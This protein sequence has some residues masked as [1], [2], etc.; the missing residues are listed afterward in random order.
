MNSP[1]DSL[2]DSSTTHVWLSPHDPLP[3]TC[4]RCGMFTDHRVK[5]K[6]VNL[7]Q[8]SADESTGCGMLVLHIFLH[9]A[10]GPIGWIISLLMDGGKTENGLKTV[11]EKTKL[12]IPQCLLCAGM[13]TPEVIDAQTEP[14]RLLFRVHPQFERRLSELKN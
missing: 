10:L 7:V 9:V 11:K 1:A 2:F 3:N 6:H 5:V 4:C 8:R 13:G 12:K 14:T